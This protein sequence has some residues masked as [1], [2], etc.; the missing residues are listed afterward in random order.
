MLD[1]QKLP[2][3]ALEALLAFW[4]RQAGAHCRAG[5]SS[6]LAIGPVVGFVWRTVTTSDLVKNECYS[7]I[8]TLP[9]VVVWIV[10]V[11][12]CVCVCVCDLVGSNHNFGGIYHLHLHGNK[13]NDSPYLNLIEKSQIS[14]YFKHDLIRVC[15]G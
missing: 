5:A 10:V 9:I 12:V 3:Q 1:A 14:Y 8:L 4:Q 15:A 6:R 13:E 7:R 11:C 2:S